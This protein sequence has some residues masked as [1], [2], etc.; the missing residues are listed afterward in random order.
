MDPD[1]IVIG[2]G[3]SGCVV[4]N[5]LSGP[6]GGTVLL[7]EAGGSS[8]GLK[9]RMPLAATK[10]WFNPESDW[11]MLSE[12]EPALGGRKIGVPRGKALGGSSAING[13][14]YNRGSPHDFEQWRDLGLNGWDYA[15]VL[16]YFR[17]VE[18]HWRGSGRFHGDRGDLP[19]TS[20][21]YVSPLT[22]DLL[23]TARQAGLPIVDDFCGPNPE[24]VGL[25]DVNISKAGRRMSAADAFLWPIRHRDTLTVETGARVLG[26]KVEGGR[27]VAVTYL[28][29]GATHV[30]RARKEIIISAGAVHSPQVLLCAGI[31][32]ADELKRVGVTPVHD[33]PGVGRNFND[34]PGA[35]FEFKSKLPRTLN[36]ELRF[37]RLAVRLAQ[38]TVGLGGPASCPPLVGIGSLRTPYV[39]R[40]PDLRFV[41]AGATLD[42]KV[43]FPG[44][45]RQGEHKMTMRFAV[46]HPRSRGS[47]TLA[48]NDPLAQP[49][50]L[51]NLLS[52][53]YDLFRLRQY[54]KF[55]IGLIRQSEFSHVAGS[56]TRP[57]PE[58]S[59]DI[60]LDNYLRSVAETTSHPMGSCR[61]G[62]DA[63]AVVDSECRVRGISG[64][65]VVDASV[66]PT[67]ISGNPNATAIMLA[68]RVSDMILGRPPLPRGNVT[69]EEINQG[70]KNVVA[71]E[72]AGLTVV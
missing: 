70:K 2:G 36:G 47:I 45:T 57:S 9:Y 69:A 59:S 41:L 63:D 54:Y 16:P 33:L 50:I 42:S 24:G 21:R 28:R 18:S 3:S 52:D 46:A 19:V 8:R 61:M 23:K 22:D 31:G 4:A 7:L 40:S 27:A 43:W 34:Q 10:L 58:P 44:F 39:E 64:L 48:S 71:F 37:D 72:E 56:I 5:R 11:C 53:P 38:W 62:V 17:R 15:S 12:P 6:G 67:Q 30:V 1:Y 25:S 29:N 49:R 60:E 65:R 13:T 26:V 68:D 20:L 55:L 35:S 32:P 51:F 14:I 66:F